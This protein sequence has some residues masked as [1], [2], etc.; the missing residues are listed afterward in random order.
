MIGLFAPR[1][2]GAN[3]TGNA[4]VGAVGSSSAVNE[5]TVLGNSANLAASAKEPIAKD[6]R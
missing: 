1:F 3:H 6:H 4:Y 2:A 5:I